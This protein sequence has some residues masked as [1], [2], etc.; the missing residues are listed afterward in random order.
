[1]TSNPSNA[2]AAT[3]IL[4]DIR[5]RIENGAEFRH[6]NRAEFFVKV[7]ENFKLYKNATRVSDRELK[8]LRSIAAG[9]LKG[10][11]KQ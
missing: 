1:M 4:A 10:G 8:L 6:A 9:G 2:V 7:R 3:Q 11:K 5:Q